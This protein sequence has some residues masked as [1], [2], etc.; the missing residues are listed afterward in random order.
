MNDR[1][2]L[3]KGVADFA[4]MTGCGRGLEEIPAPGPESEV[5]LAGISRFA[6]RTLIKSLVH[7][8]FPIIT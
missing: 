5:R 2:W 8:P 1:T 6:S 4:A 3:G 7:L